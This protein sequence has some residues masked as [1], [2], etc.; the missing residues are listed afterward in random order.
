MQAYKDYA[1][2]HHDNHSVTLAGLFVDSE[3]PYIGASPDGM[4]NCACCGKGVLEVKCPFCFKENIPDE[5]EQNFCMTKIG[6]QWSLKRNH[7]YFYQVQTQLN[8]CKVQYCDFVVWTEQN[9]VIERIVVDKP[10]FEDILED[11]KHFFIYGMLPELLGKWYTRKP[12]ADS[13]GIVQDPKLQLDDTIVDTEDYERCWCYCNQPSYG[14]MIECENTDCTI[15][16]FHCDCLRIRCP[17]KGKWYC[18]SCRKQPRKKKVK[19]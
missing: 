11:V 3:H 4:V 14:T 7:S 19:Q 8:V 16:W 17:P 12:V 6:D 13:N 10:F 9:T 1:S 2:K 15:Q 18:P 5:E